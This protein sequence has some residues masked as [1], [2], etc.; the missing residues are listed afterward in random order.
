MR[1]GRRYDS[2]AVPTQQPTRAPGTDA[3]DVAA[4]TPIAAWVRTRDGEPALRTMCAAAGIDSHLLAGSGGSLPLAR[5]EAFLAALR[6]HTGS[7]DALLVASGAVG[8]AP[9]RGRWLRWFATPGLL[10]RSRARAGWLT[11]GG[12]RITCAA[13]GLG[14]A[15]LRYTG[16]DAGGRFTCL[17]RQGR[18]M[19]LPTAWAL[20]PAVVVETQCRARG[21]DACVYKV[22]W[23]GRP[24]W[25]PA[26]VAAGVTIAGLAWISAT[27]WVVSGVAALAAG[28]AYALE[29]RRMR[30]ANRVT[31]AVFGSAFRQATTGLAPPVRASEPAVP[32]AASPN[33][34]EE[35]SVFR[36]EGDFWRIT[37]EGKTVLIQGSR[38]LSLLVH[39]LRNPGEEIHV[40]ALDALT[41]SDAALPARNATAVHGESAR[42]LGDA[43]E[44]FDVQAKVAYRRRIDE[45]REELEDSEVCNDLGRASGARAELEAI[46][47]HLRVGTG[48]RGRTRRASSNAD[49]VRVAVTRR[50]R[51]AIAQIAKHHAP[52]GMHLTASIRTG[53]SCSYAP[54]DQ[55][56]WR[57]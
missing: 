31:A 30:A 16:A 24:R 36:Q 43:G 7:D 9:G 23:H 3:V 47:E 5:L 55:L 2:G 37:F 48:P 17:F 51:A 46:T 45:L 14:S 25:T 11:G 26:V 42:D 20:P 40:T 19:H 22:H 29:T 50:I 41:P 13:H 21:E 28:L 12:G 6:E 34:P 54:A 15:T 38:G 53:Y 39:L 8:E 10:Y 27:S 57:T 49:R 1:L 44:I 18:L 32:A 56:V 35:G 4:F 33:A 52:L